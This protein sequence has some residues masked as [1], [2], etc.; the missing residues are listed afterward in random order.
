LEATVAAERILD[1]LDASDQNE[2][3]HPGG[4]DISKIHKIEIRNASYRYGAKKI[5][6]NVNLSFEPGR[7]YILSGPNGAGKTTIV[8]SLLGFTDPDSGIILINDQPYS[9]YRLSSIRNR[10]SWVSQDLNLFNLSVRD[11]IIFGK[12]ILNPQEQKKYDW[13]LEMSKFADSLKRSSRNDFT[14]VA[15]KGANFSG[16]EKQR[17]C[18]ARAFFKDHDVLILDEANANI[19]QSSFETIMNT[20][21]SNR[22]EKIIIFITHVD[23]FLRYADVI[24]EV[25]GETIIRKAA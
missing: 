14:H 12:P 19:S 21:Y 4:Q 15:E 3:R 7:L 24:Y 13:S 16:G 6:V 2:R 20:I 10:M 17:L 23:R 11:N 8:E 9:H 18:L 22:A 5:L 1:V 25:S